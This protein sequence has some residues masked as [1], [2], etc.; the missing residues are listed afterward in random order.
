LVASGRRKG[1][2]LI[3]VAIGAPSEEAR[4]EANLELLEYGFS[5]YRRRLPIHA[6]EEMAAP[7]IRYSGGE[8]PLR[9]ARPVAV[10]LRRGQRLD[11]DV[12]APAEVEGPVR[13]GAV[14]GRATVLVDGR[15]AGTVSLRA[16][17]A[18]PKASAFD[19]TRSFLGDNLIP[20]AVAGFVIL[21]GGVLLYRRLSGRSD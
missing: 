17:R 9:A 4:Y 12:R 6:G 2:D 20:I 1:V 3:S 19:R 10:G 5:Q 14:L 21:I 8:L 13:R 11:V 18:I 15:H 16:A 7:A